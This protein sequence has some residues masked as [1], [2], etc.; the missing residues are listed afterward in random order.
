MRI[1]T[2]LSALAGALGFVLVTQAAADAQAQDIRD[3]SEMQAEDG[4]D[5]FEKRWNPVG[6]RPRQVE[7]TFSSFQIAESGGRVTIDYDVAAGDW[8]ELQEHRIT[9]WFDL[10]VRRTQN[11][12]WPGY[13]VTRV[14]PRRDGEV[15][16]PTWLDLPENRQVKLCLLGTTPG[17]NLA[18]GQ[19]YYC[20]RWR[21]FSVGSGLDAPT[22]ELSFTIRYRRGY[23]P[24]PTYPWFDEWPEGFT[25]PA[26]PQLEI[27]PNNGPDN[28]TNT[29]TD[30]T[31]DFTPGP[32]LN[33]NP[34]RG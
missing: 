7:V 10:Y 1:R 21:E 5:R 34:G 4:L 2:L 9:L 25:P 13:T 22:R 17:D 33:L 23:Q 29:G 19:G 11:P 16:F 32:D 31:P 8:D 24:Y 28:G 3:P 18:F 15:R 26:P 12:D 30:N 14:L 20:V 6:E 27:L